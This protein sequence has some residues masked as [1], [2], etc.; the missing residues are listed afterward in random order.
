MLGLLLEEPDSVTLI[1]GVGRN[2]AVCDAVVEKS[3]DGV[4][5]GV[6]DEDGVAD[7]IGV[8]DSVP[9]E[10]L[11]HNGEE[12]GVGVGVRESVCD[13]SCVG[14]A[15]RAMLTVLVSELEAVS[16]DDAVNVGDVSVEGDKLSLDDV[17]GGAV[18][19]AL[20]C[21]VFF[22]SDTLADSECVGVSGGDFVT[23]RVLVQLLT[24]V[25]DSVS[26]VEYKALSVTVGGTLMVALVE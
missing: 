23:V 7:A 5:L 4:L 18:M 1:L 14:D 2:D 13:L 11:L 22:V 21:S 10:L 3:S 17:D 20:R 9:E 8:C 16:L 25:D 24:G 12:L 15:V 26:L 6:S 19:V